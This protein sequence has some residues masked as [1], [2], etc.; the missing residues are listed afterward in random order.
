MKIKIYI[1]FILFLLNQS[2]IQLVIGETSGEKTT[3]TESQQ[4]EDIIGTKSAFELG[5]EIDNEIQ[6]ELIVIRPIIIMRK[7]PKV[8]TKVVARLEAGTRLKKL[9][10]KGKWYKVSDGTHT[11]YVR[12]DMLAWSNAL[13][14]AHKKVLKSVKK[15]AENK[16]LAHKMKIAEQKL[17]LEKKI[18]KHKLT[19]EKKIAEQKLA[20]EKKIA[21]QKK[22]ALEKLAALEEKKTAQKIRVQQKIMA[23]DKKTAV[24]KILVEEKKLAQEKKLAEQ[25]KLAQEKKLAKEKKLAEQLKLAEEKKLAQEKKLADAAEKKRVREEKLKA[26]KLKEEQARIERERQAKIQ[27]EK[28]MVVVK[29]LINMR[30][31][32]ELNTRIVAKLVMGTELKQLAKKGKWFKVSDGT[33]TGYIREDMLAYSDNLTDEQQKMVNHYR[34]KIEDENLA[35]ETTENK[36]AEKRKQMIEEKQI[37][38]R[39]KEDQKKIEQEKREQ[40]KREIELAAKRK[41]EEIKREKLRLEKLARDKIEADK[42]AQN[43]KEKEIEK[44]RIKRL[45]ALKKIKEDERKRQSEII[46]VQQEN[47]MKLLLEKKN[48]AE[49]EEK[50]IEMLRKQKIVYSSFGRRD[51]FVPVEQS[52]VNEKELNIDQ[53]KLVGI[54]WDQEDPMAV[55]EHNSE[56]GIS[57][58]LREGDKI[59]NGKVAYINYEKITFEILEYGVYRSYTLNLIK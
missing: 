44:A 55:L 14:E 33:H 42:F 20:L 47:K 8:N 40:I 17:A 23:R 45:L 16:K 28:S 30:E 15:A 58:T 43:K 7:V 32:P 19:L 27:S 22:R 39:F 41:E 10:K 13:T 53:M 50:R 21:K 49:E 9:A 4:I 11:G 54:I 59:A 12:E 36:L 18:A 2:V 48:K 56:S 35:R 46:R 25:L 5:Q 51:P 34:Q 3:S 26:V 57:V 52:N 31:I 37:A 29:S 38:R 24:K 6:K 1:L